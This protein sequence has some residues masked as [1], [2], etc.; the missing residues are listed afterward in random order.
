MGG[1]L[2]FEP[3]CDNDTEDVEGELDGD[4][5]STTCVLSSLGC[6]NGNNGVE[7]TGS[8]AVNQTGC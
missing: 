7:N 3:V 2:Q 4:E 6:P 5:L 8:D 1:G